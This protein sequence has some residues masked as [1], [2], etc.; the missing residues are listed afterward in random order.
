[1]NRKTANC[2]RS[3]GRLI[4]RFLNWF[5]NV[6][7]TCPMMLSTDLANVAE[8][9]L[10]KNLLKKLTK[11]KSCSWTYVLKACSTIIGTK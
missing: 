11:L 2:S 4:K 5:R 6:E 10:W 9:S 3:D 1:M 7:K 8:K